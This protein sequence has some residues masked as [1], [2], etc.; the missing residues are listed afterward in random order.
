MP[1]EQCL[2]KEHPL[3]RSNGRYCTKEQYAQDRVHN[4]NKRL[5]YE[6]DKYYR[7]YLAVANDNV[8]LERK[9]AELKSLL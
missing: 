7:M 3:R 8:R 5:R 9:L 4:E 2:F 1:K 6:R